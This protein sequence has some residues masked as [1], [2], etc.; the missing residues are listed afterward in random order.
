MRNIWIFALIVLVLSLFVACGPK[1]PGEEVKMEEEPTP[2]V[3]KEE[4]PEQPVPAQEEVEEIPIEERVKLEMIHF[5]F[6]RYRLLPE[7]KQIL[8]ENGRLLKMYPQVKILIEGHCDE[9]G[10]IEYNLALGEKRARAA[11][12]YLKNLGID[13]SRIS[14]ISY[15]KERPLD[16]RHNEDAWYMNRRDEFKIKSK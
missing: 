14:I 1:P 10:T 4:P 15:G 2:E 13:P 7:A 8:N 11:Q 5:E 16:L 12:E 3:T 9:R 6:D